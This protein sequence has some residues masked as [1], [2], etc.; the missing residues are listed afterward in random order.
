MSA[1]KMNLLVSALATALV[2]IGCAKKKEAKPLAPDVNLMA[3]LKDGMK[4]KGGPL[5]AMN[6]SFTRVKTEDGYKI[7]TSFAN[8]EGLWPEG[9]GIKGS[10]I[11]AVAVV[12][13]ENE[14]VKATV[15]SGTT[16]EGAE[17]E[18]LIGCTKGCEGAIGY[19][20]ATYGDDKKIEGGF[21]VDFKTAKTA[22]KSIGVAKIK[23]AEK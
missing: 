8:I 22:N 4:L 23:K 13:K 21:G 7:S 15:E 9:S 20:I 6:G 16:V 2:L 17:L 18:V 11:N 10:G 12:P 14:A 19:V 5:D 3:A 1:M